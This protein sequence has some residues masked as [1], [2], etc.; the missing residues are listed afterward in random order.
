MKTPYISRDFLSLIIFSLSLLKV[1]V[2]AVLPLRNISRLW[3]DFN[4]IQIPIFLRPAGFKL[5][6]WIFGCNLEEMK[7]SDLKSY[8]NLSEFF[9]RELKYGARPIEPGLLVSRKK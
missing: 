2:A 1:K 9:T 6:S 4:S 8:R 5:Y 3:G 7:N